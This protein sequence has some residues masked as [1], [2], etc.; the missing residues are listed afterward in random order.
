MGM[1]LNS[2]HTK[3]T[4]TNRPV[5]PGRPRLAS[6][7]RCPCPHY[8]CIDKD[9]RFISHRNSHLGNSHSNLLPLQPRLNR[10]VLLIEVAHIRHQITDDI[11]MGQRVDFLGLIQIGIDAA[12]ACQR[13]RS[14]NVHRAWTADAFTARPTESQCWIDLVFDFQQRVQHHRSAFIQIDLVFLQKWFF[15][16][17]LRIPSV[18]FKCLQ[19]RLLLWFGF[20]GGRSSWC[21]IVQST[22]L[23]TKQYRSVFKLK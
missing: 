20:S 7:V 17:F 4:R 16:R 19:T 9:I 5:W 6:I 23:R 13:I 15:T 14:T 2:M 21:C 22:N 8:S 3:C 1:M 10:C 12:D 18:D 11:Q